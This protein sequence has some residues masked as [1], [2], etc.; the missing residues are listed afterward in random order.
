MVGGQCYWI[1]QGVLKLWGSQFGVYGMD[2][3]T[4]RGPMYGYIRGG[5]KGV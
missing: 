3:H 4:A 1:N 2:V 5:C